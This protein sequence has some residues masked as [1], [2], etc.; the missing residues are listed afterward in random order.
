MDGVATGRLTLGCCRPTTRRL[1]HDLSAT[2]T[3]AHVYVIF[4]LTI[5]Y[6][7]CGRIPLSQTWKNDRITVMKMHDEFQTAAHGADMIAEGGKEQVRTLFKTRDTIL[8]NV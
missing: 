6:S 8:P 4:Q 7:V 5:A 2:W 1:S 3:F